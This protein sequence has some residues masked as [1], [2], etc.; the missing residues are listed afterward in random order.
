MPIEVPPWLQAPDV[1]ADYARG[2][3]IGAQVSEARQRLDAQQSEASM[4]AQTESNQQQQEHALQ[5]QRIATTDAY[6]QQQIQ[7]R[8]QQLDQVKA[9]NDQKTASAARQF[10]AKQQ[11]QTGFAKIDSDP[12]MT[13]EQKDAA[14]T[15]L[16]MS[17]APMMGMAGTEAAS[18]LRD[19]RP[20]KP[21]VPATV[22][23]KGDFYQITQPNG[24]I[25]MHAKPKPGSEGNV[26]VQLPDPS[27]P[28]SEATVFRT[29]SRSQAEATIPTLPANLQTN[30]VNKAALS[31]V[32]RRTATNS[33]YFSIADVKAAY[34]AHSLTRDQASKIL[35]DQF[36]LKPA[37]ANAQ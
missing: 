9:M 3:Q 33:K 10:V 6:Q 31:G 29:M 5:Q 30:A 26:T 28:N 12:N 4:R 25:T 17:L 23:D 8:K 32:P 19:M 7:L 22:E 16:T 15:S 2:L 13:P 1:G 18:M 14:K 11:W 34:A 24:S 36:G 27:Q 20:P 37:T 35:A 21:T